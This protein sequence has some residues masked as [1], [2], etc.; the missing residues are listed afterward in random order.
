MR[1]MPSCR[2]ILLFFFT[3][4]RSLVTNLRSVLLLELQVSRLLIGFRHLATAHHGLKNRYCDL[5]V[6]VLYYYSYD[7]GGPVCL[8]GE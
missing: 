1:A 6:H 8:S 7:I 5:L 2:G 3:K 4:L